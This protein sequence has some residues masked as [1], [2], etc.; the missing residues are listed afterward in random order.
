LSGKTV[1]KEGH[2]D[3]LDRM[4]NTI[5]KETNGK[6]DITLIRNHLI[7]FLLVGHDSTSSLLTSL[8]YVLTQHPEVE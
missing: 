4:L 5:D 8:I 7:L 3:V 2:P 6:M 1:S